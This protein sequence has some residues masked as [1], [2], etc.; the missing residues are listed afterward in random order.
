MREPPPLFRRQVVA[1]EVID[2]ERNRPVEVVCEIHGGLPRNR[3]DEVAVPVRKPC[4]CDPSGRLFQRLLRAVAPERG[5]QPRVERLDAETDPVGEAANEL[6]LGRGQRLRVGFDGNLGFRTGAQVT[7]NQGEQPLQPR[8]VEQRRRSAAEIDRFTGAGR[9]M[10]RQHRLET[11]EISVFRLAGGGGFGIESAIPALRTAERDMDVIVHL[12]RPCISGNVALFCRN[13]IPGDDAGDDGALRNGPERAAVEGDLRGV[14]EQEELPFGHVETVDA[15]G[16]DLFD[17]PVVPEIFPGLDEQI[18]SFVETED[19]HFVARQ[20]VNALEEGFAVVAE[21]HDFAAPERFIVAEHLTPSDQ[22]TAAVVS[23]RHGFPADQDELPGEECR[24]ADQQDSGRR[25]KMN[26]FYSPIRHVA[27][28]SSRTIARLR[29]ERNSPRFAVTE[30]E[31]NSH[32]L[33]TG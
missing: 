1:G 16:A 24:D 2:A 29:R 4:G 26:P 5:A 10:P 13:S 15:G 9:L 7:Y 17:Q 20:G 11:V 18:E 6:H 31:P 30:Y 27:S 21:E 3:V 32:P 19:D 33:L 28:P 22:Q 12:I 14:A 23:R 25:Q 8:F